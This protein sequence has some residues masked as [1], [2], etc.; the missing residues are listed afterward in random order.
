[1]M[2]VRMGLGSPKLGFGVWSL[3]FGVWG[4]GFGVWSFTR[5][6][7][8][9]IAGGRGR[10][11]SVQ[12]VAAEC[13]AFSL[14]ECNHAPRL[15]LQCAVFV[16]DGQRRGCIGWCGSHCSLYLE[17]GDEQP[18]P[19]P[20]R[21]RRRLGL[22]ADMKGGGRTLLLLK[23]REGLKKEW[24]GSE[25]AEVEVWLN[26]NWMQRVQPPLRDHSHWSCIGCALPQQHSCQCN[27][28]CNPLEL[29]KLTHFH[30]D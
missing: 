4:L 6:S 16:C 13:Y 3:G 10:Q 24:G 20:P 25:I 27:L 2:V 22:G 26:H 23:G 14:S 19:P 8:C 5:A 9:R 21:G 12:R 15:Q 29:L 18:P 7:C 1:M 30:N 28:P 11:V 17:G